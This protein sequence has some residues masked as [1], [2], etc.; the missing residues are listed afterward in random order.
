MHYRHAGT[1]EILLLALVTLSLSFACSPGSAEDEDSAT[2]SDTVVAA[3]LGSVAESPP[4]SSP[5]IPAQEQEAQPLNVSQMGYDRGSSDAPVRV[6]EVSDFGCGYC[7]IF[8]QETFP[9][10]REVYVEAGL[11]Q[12]KFIPFVLGRFPNGLEASIA[13]ECSGE[14]DSFFSMQGRLFGDQSG[15]KNS[16]DPF[17]FF[18]RLAEEE[19]LDV[20]R[21]NRCIDGGWRENQVR[22]NVRFGREIGVRGTPTFL[23][24]GIPISG[25]LPLDTFRDI[26]DIALTEKGV[27]PPARDR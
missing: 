2:P 21:F 13:A 4:S 6:L 20:E 23:I 16:I 3:I 5:R 18:A 8:H 17:P 10:L 25:A 22:A 1:I 19:G 12:W 15:W 26:L 24:D 11:V 14:Q 7:R 27:T 9:T